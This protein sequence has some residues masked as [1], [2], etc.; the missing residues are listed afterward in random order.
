MEKSNQKV[1]IKKN[2][3]VAVLFSSLLF[4]GLLVCVICDFA[5]SNLFTWS[6]ITTSSIVFAWL[7]F[8]SIFYFEV[9]SYFVTQASNSGSPS[10]HPPKCQDYN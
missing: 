2:T 10:S 3:I 7:V 9:E 5:S 8:I 4:V 6:R 1:E